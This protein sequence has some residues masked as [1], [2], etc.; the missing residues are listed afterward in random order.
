MMKQLLMTILGLQV[1]TSA[2]KRGG[3]WSSGEEGSPPQKRAR[4]GSSSE[5]GAVSAHQAARSTETEQAGTQ[6]GL[7]AAEALPGQA[8]ALSAEASSASGQSGGPLDDDGPDTE[9]DDGLETALEDYEKEKDRYFYLR[10]EVLLNAVA[11]ESKHLRDATLAH[12][13][14]PSVEAQPAD[15][16]SPTSRSDADKL[17]RLAGQADRLQ[18]RVRAII[19][20]QA[21]RFG[22]YS[23]RSDYENIVNN[24]LIPGEANMVHMAII[25]RVYGNHV[26]SDTP[27]EEWCGYIVERCLETDNAFAFELVLPIWKHNGYPFGNI[28]KTLKTAMANDAV[29]CTKVLYDH[30]VC[31][32]PQD[33]PCMME[34]K[35]YLR[36]AQSCSSSKAP[37]DSTKQEK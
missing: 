17:T 2:M 22:Y 30:L 23:S 28:T 32:S 12:L 3:V 29:K 33:D 7:A 21:E 26:L 31:D 16:P 35:E 14:L 19:V 13:H 24:I 8:P 6:S 11:K 20:E 10:D 25:L 15:A 34:A 27:T 36:L 37:G 18:E 5:E 1:L 4:A 9:T